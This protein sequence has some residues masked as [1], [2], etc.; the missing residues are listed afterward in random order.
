[1]LEQN[2]VKDL[3]GLNALWVPSHWFFFILVTRK[4]HLEVSR[5]NGCFCFFSQAA[6]ELHEKE[7]KIR[8]L[9]WEMGMFMHEVQTKCAG[10]TEQSSLANSKYILWVIFQ[11]AV[12]TELA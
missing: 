11:R 9:Y 8:V 1:M 3:D 6:A 7:K 12:I 4:G 5:P 2:I 10:N